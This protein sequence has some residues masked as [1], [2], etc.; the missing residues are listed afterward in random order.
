[1]AEAPAPGLVTQGLNF[2]AT[3]G[4]TANALGLPIG[5]ALINLFGAHQ[6]A[7]HQGGTVGG[8]PFGGGEEEE[9][10]HHPVRPP[11]K[12]VQ[13]AKPK[14]APRPP[15]PPARPPTVAEEEEEEKEEA[16]HHAEPPHQAGPAS[17]PPAGSLSRDADEAHYSP[18]PVS[19]LQHLRSLEAVQQ[20]V[21]RGDAA[22]AA[23]L[24]RH[25]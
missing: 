10:E 18:P 3:V 9:E 17:S 12:H 6:G 7:V 8:F 13:A 20:L 25:G 14:S 22:A 15:R 21:R 2:M 5:P 23:F 4:H 19:K 16:A 11:Q 1:M 24:S